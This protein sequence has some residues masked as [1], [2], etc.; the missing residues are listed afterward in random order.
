MGLHTFFN[1]RSIAIIGVSENPKKVGYLVVDRLIEQGF[2][3]EL[4]LVNPKRETLFNRKLYKSVGEIGKPIDLAVLAVPADV[5]IGLLDELHEAGVKN[6]V[7]YAAGFK[8]VDTEGALKEQNLRLKAET[9]GITILGPNCIGYVNTINGAN[10][11]FLKH[12]AP[13][14]NIGFVSQSGALGSLMVDYLA[15]HHN[16]GFSYFISL[17]NKMMIDEVDVLRFL[18][19][20]PDTKVVGMYLEDVKRGEEFKKVLKETTLVKPV[21][22]LKSGSTKAGSKAAGSHTG[23]MVGDDTIFSAVFE[24]CGAIRA[25]QFFEFMSILKMVSF[26]RIPTSRDILVLS[27][28]GGVGVLL[29]D[30]IIKNHLTLVTIPEELREEIKKSIGSDKVTIHNPIDLLGDA[31]AF[32]YRQAIATTLTQKEVGAVV[33]LLTPQ[34]NT[35]VEET[36]TAIIEAQKAFDRPIYPVFMGEKSVGN[37]HALFEKERIASFFTYDFVAKA[38]AKL[39]AYKEFLRKNF[40]GTVVTS[41]EPIASFAIPKKSLLTPLETNAI[42][43][44][45]GLAPVPLYEVHSVAQL[46]LVL[47]KTTFPVVLKIASNTI[48]HKTDVGGIAVNVA[49]KQQAASEYTRMMAIPQ[50]QGVYVQSMKKGQE[51]IVGAKRDP[52]FG[53]VVVIGMGGVLAEL[54]KSVVSF[55]YPFTKA[56]MNEKLIGTSVSQ[57][58]YGY[59]GATPVSQDDVYHLLSRIGL[60]LQTQPTVMELDLNPVLINDGKLQLVD[61][62]IITHVEPSTSV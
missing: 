9:Y 7:L 45:M 38:L 37:S 47:A 57:L 4:Y 20:D 51:I 39:I 5:A 54:V 44:Q 23:S 42:L 58:L 3:G 18:K 60:L 52:T 34:A 50:V 15:D 29:T 62:R 43:T 36:A 31:S 26:D 40:R 16:F 46:D 25:E 55:V 59:R 11:T 24:Q 49:N 53:I 1:P 13:R 32:H 33:I 19:D 41:E 10:L 8:E 27:N 21:V 30:E 17:G 48:T 6:I 14:G 61:G 22:I 28:A 2:K 56:E 12:P 35:E